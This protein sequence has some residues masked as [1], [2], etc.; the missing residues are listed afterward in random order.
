MFGRKK[1]EAQHQYD[2]ARYRAVLHCSICNGEQVAGFKDR[3]TGKFEEV[4]LIRSEEDLR[5]FQ[6]RY[7]VE[8]VSKEY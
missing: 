2:P 5:E 8:Q 6:R 1:K 4:M 7:G 3:E